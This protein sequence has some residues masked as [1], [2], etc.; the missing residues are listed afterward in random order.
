MFLFLGVRIKGQKTVKQ[1]QKAVLEGIVQF[2]KSIKYLKWQKYH[3]GE[4]VDINI[5]SSKYKGTTTFL[6]N[7]ALQIH[8]FD[9]DDDVFYRLAV[10]MVHTT[11]F[12]EHRRIIL[13]P[14]NGEF[15]KASAL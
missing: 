10:V 7:P 1:G 9:V 11:K 4:Y 3:N 15:A 8:E 12:S 13:L 6:Q 5:H 14:I 2:N